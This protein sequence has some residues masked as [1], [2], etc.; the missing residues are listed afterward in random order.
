[1]EHVITE[2]FR[3]GNLVARYHGS[4]GKN[5]LIITFYP[6]S[7]TF[8]LDVRGFGEGF[9]ARRAIDCIHIIPRENNWYQD[10]DLLEAIE[11]VRR[12]AAPYDKVI[13]YGSSMGGYAE[14]RFGA[15]TGSDVALAISPQY[16]IDPS[17]VSFDQ[18]WLADASQLD[19]SLE[20]GW[21]SPFVR[22]AY[23]VYDPADIDRRHLDLYR[24]S[25]TEIVDISLKNGGHPAIGVL[26]DL[27]LLGKLVLGVLDGTLTPGAIV[28]E[29]HA[30]R[31][32]SAWYFTNLSLR[33][34]SKSRR[35][36]FARLAYEKAPEKLEFI[37]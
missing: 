21:A 14:I 18:R 13:T 8:S 9:F 15:R 31:R 28:R 19:F 32:E 36:I 4:F 33:C 27:G 25:G 37:V 3:T 5:N 2:I 16:S 11:T 7:D 34:R 35:E 12:F 30:R 20:R 22:K 10:P 6:Y 29:A 17:V 1:M 23:V 24:R 26:A